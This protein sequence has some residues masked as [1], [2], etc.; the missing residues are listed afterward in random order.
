MFNNGYSSLNVLVRNISSTG[1][2]LSGDELICLPEEF[3]LQINNGFGAF[4]SHWV[5]RVWFRT[6]TIGVAF[7]DSAHE[8]STASQPQGSQ[9]AVLARGPGREGIA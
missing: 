7:V 6:D 5:K 1:A 9:S 2:K 4:T 3:E 8:R